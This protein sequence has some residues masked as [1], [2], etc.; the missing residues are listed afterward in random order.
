M[1]PKPARTWPRRLMDFLASGRLA[2]ILLA[3]L[4]LLY[5]LYLWIPQWDPGL[6]FAEAVWLQEHGTGGWV[7]MVTGLTDIQHSLWLKGVYAMLFVNLA[8][9]MARRLRPALLLMRFPDRPPAPRADWVTWE[10]QAAGVEPA[11]VARALESSGFKTGIRGD[12]VYGLRGR[13][14]LAGHWIFHVGLLA[15]LVAGVSLASAPETFRGAVGVGEGEPFDLHTS[16]F[17]S[18]NDVPTETMPGLSFAVERVDAV[19][20][21]GQVRRFD[22][23]MSTPE[24]TRTDIGLNRPLRRAPY[25]VVANGFGYMPGWALVDQGDRMLRGAWVKL[26]PFPEMEEESFPIGPD[27]R[28]VHV[29]FYPDHRGS[30]VE[31][32]TAS[33]DARRPRFL[34]RIEERDDVVF[35]GLLEPGQRVSLGDGTSFQFLPEIRRY[36]M[37]E[38]LQERGHRVVFGIL[39]AIILGLVLRYARTRKEILVE[40]RPDALCVHGHSEMLPSLF[41][42]EMERILE[43]MTRRPGVAAA[44]EALA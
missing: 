25:Q 43:A 26:M 22:V 44:R 7:L 24:G 37:L 42:E 8:L 41:E 40:I 21:D 18:T 14:A 16:R 23:T 19:V 28:T 11:A 32:R 20:E 33:W 1:D 29:T 38:V 9:C 30:G 35:T 36:V 13:F 17:L 31:H 3:L 39:A 15:L 6:R 5:L 12:S 10:V 27:G 4:V 34:T 2:V